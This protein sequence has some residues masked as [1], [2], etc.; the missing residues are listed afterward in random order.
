MRNLLSRSFLSLFLVI[1]FT[2]ALNAQPKKICFFDDFGNTFLFTNIQVTGTDTYYGEGTYDGY[3][4]GKATIWLDLSRGIHF[5]IVEIHAI[6]GEPDGCTLYSDSFILRGVSYVLRSGGQTIEYFGAGTWESFCFG[7]L[8]NIGIWSGFG[9]CKNFGANDLNKKLSPTQGNQNAKPKNNNFSLKVIPNPIK[10]NA[11]LEYKLTSAGKI[12]ITI[13]DFLHRPVRVLV[14]EYK[15]PGNYAITW[16]AV[17][18][19]GS[20]VSPGLYQ[21]V[22]TMG[23]KLYSNTIQ[24]LQ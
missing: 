2:T 3:P 15:T 8:L 16:D 24:V 1:S 4:N 11:Q 21:V 5:G 12:N 10:T 6:N 13:Y 22:V 14:N 18:A 20:R 23:G 17:S 9:P 19:N 7:S